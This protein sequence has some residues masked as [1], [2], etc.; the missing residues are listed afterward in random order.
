MQAHGALNTHLVLRPLS[1][2]LR[3]RVAG[4]IEALA[5]QAVDCDP[6]GV[7]EDL[8]DL[9]Y[10]DGEAVRALN[11]GELGLLKSW[12][13]KTDEEKLLGLMTQALHHQGKDRRVPRATPEQ[14]Q[15]IL[16]TQVEVGVRWSEKE[17][18]RL[19]SWQADVLIKGLIVVSEVQRLTGDRRFGIKALRQAVRTQF[20]D[21]LPRPMPPRRDPRPPQAETPRGEGAEARGVTRWRQPSR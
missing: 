7:L 12:L 15:I 9:V 1:L 4:W 21:A 13:E 11:A 18:R 6:D 3:D 5:H 19:T 14:L 16:E 10:G 17:L 20:P 2:P 8:D